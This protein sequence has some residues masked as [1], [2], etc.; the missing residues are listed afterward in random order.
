MPTCV[1]VLFTIVVLGSIGL[2]MLCVSMLLFNLLGYDVS[3]IYELLI[4]ITSYVYHI[5]LVVLYI[6]L[7]WVCSFAIRLIWSK[8]DRN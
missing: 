6:I 5:G 8:H 4:A 2:L 7:I 1:K 3:P